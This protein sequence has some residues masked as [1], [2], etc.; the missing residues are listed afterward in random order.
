[1]RINPRNSKFQA[2]AMVLVISFTAIGLLALAGVLS[3]AHS[4]GFRVGRTQDLQRVQ[5]AAEGVTTKAVSSI[6]QD[7][8]TNG[9]ATVDAN[10]T[11]YRT[12][13]PTQTEAPA[14]QYLSISSPSG[15]AGAMDVT[16]VVD[17]NFGLLNTKYTGLKG[18]GATYRVAAI[19]KDSR[20]AKSAPGSMSID[21]QLAEIPI[22]QFSTF[23]GVDME[24]FPT[25]IFQLNGRVHCNA[26]I[27]LNPNIVLTFYDEVT[28]SG[29][30]SPNP[31]P[32]NIE[33]TYSGGSIVY[34]ADH[35]ER[36]TSFNLPAGGK[37]TASLMHQLIEIPPSSESATSPL[38]KLRYYNQADM[39]I[40]ITDTN[41]TAFSGS[42]NNFATPIP[43]SIIGTFVTTNAVFYDYREGRN[44]RATDI[45]VLNLNANLISATSLLGRSVTTLYIADLRTNTL[46]SYAAVRLKRCQTLSGQGMTFATPNPLYT[47]GHFNAGSS[48]LG[49]TNTT[50]ALR[51]GLA[52][53]AITILSSS[54]SDNN[55]ASSL[56]ARTA[57]A[58]TVNAGIF[59]G[60]VQT[61]NGNSG[62]GHEKTLRLLENWS[63][64]NLNFNGSIAVLCYSQTANTSWGAA[65]VYGAPAKRIFRYDKNFD[66]SGKMPYATPVVR[67]VF[68]DSWKTLSSY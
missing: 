60:V 15:T 3:W 44:V 30:I 32:N 48:E 37:N 47:V 61:T 4:V 41:A 31:S 5:S 26:N 11:S 7:F 39:I 50:T 64:R 28:A 62:G 58:T 17:K 25:V 63:G 65:N 9:F 43:W 29:T 10:L 68:R 53:D 14:W 45:D 67:A 51:G 1:M 20:D 36:T 57:V 12:M 24:L 19:I 56:S 55:S 34:S 49:T 52:C 35:D 16:R 22:F 33:G 46:T 13:V 66:I 54:W 38:G 23:Y 21:L 18:T 8:Y 2:Y 40:R 59:T 42:Y 6:I 27:Y